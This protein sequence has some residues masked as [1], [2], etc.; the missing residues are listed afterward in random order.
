MRP[1]PMAPMLMRLL[2]AICPKT[3]AGTMVGKPATAVAAVAVRR[4]LRRETLRIV[5]IASPLY[6]CVRCTLLRA[7]DQLSSEQTLGLILRSVRAVH[8]VRD[9]LRSERQCQIVA[10]DIASLFRIH[11][12]QV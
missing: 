3:D 6:S 10:V 12:E 1:T 7:D 2:G 9:K 8:H 4:K 11:D 5:F